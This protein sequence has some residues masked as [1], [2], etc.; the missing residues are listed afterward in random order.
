MSKS[1]SLLIRLRLYGG[2]NRYP[3]LAAAAALREAGSPPMADTTL[4]FQ[5]ES[6]ELRV[7]VRVCSHDDSELLKIA[8][9]QMGQQSVVTVGLWVTASFST[10][11]FRH[12]D[13]FVYKTRGNAPS[14]KEKDEKQE[15]D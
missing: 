8:N 11:S 15:S 6:P 9:E 3:Q 13:A 1:I 4:N 14:E 2:H 10:R 5:F 12:P 7:P